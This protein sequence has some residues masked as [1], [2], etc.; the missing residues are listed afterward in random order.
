MMEALRWRR[1]AIGDDD[2]FTPQLVSW[3]ISISM[4]LAWLVVVHLT[5]VRQ[6]P[7]EPPRPDTPWAVAFVPGIARVPNPGGPHVATSRDKQRG[8]RATNVAA[9]AGSAGM[10][11]LSA[12]ATTVARQLSANVATL[13]GDVEAVRGGVG[14][15][16]P[17]DKAALV[18]GSSGATPG[19]S[20]FGRDRD[21]R[22][23]GEVGT[24]SH[25]GMIGHAEVRVQP[26]PVVVA[27]PASGASIDAAEAGAFVR[28]QASQLQ[29]CYERSRQAG[30]ADLGGVVTLRLTLGAR[31]AVREAEIVR[32]TWSG[33]GASEVESCVL[34]SA[35]RWN[36]P[37]GQE[38][39]TVTVPI[40][41][42]R[43]GQG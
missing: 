35:R 4:A 9:A 39:A 26:L 30:A 17:G 32:R 24:V 1:R 42:T 13:I 43:G 33:P 28:G 5:P 15:K 27:P 2:D 34:T 21:A 25:G 6:A 3:S 40:S 16:E 19:V 29:Y 7:V 31:G 41:F 22:S 23:T 37:S 11:I 36:I 14:A 8:D 10:E 18:V 12:F 38:G 20:K